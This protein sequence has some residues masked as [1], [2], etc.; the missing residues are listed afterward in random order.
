MTNHFLLGKIA[1]MNKLRLLIVDDHPIVREGLAVLLEGT[2]EIEIVGQGANGQEAIR[3]AECLLPDIVLIDVQMAGMGGIEATACIRQIVPS[4]QVVIFSNFDEHEYIYQSIRAGAR[5]YV[6]KTTSLDELMKVLRAAARGES[7]LA[8]DVATRLVGHISTNRPEFTAREEEVLQLLVQGRRNK[9]IAGQL[10]ITER[11][12]KNHVA[13]M[14]T[15]LGVESRT[16]LILLV[17]KEQL[18]KL[19]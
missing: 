18:I 19:N 7:L 15:K 16:E 12:V 6:L 9:E 5:G 3:L 17:L 11:T 2:G 8:P 1:G 4:A 14:M 13:N 10:H